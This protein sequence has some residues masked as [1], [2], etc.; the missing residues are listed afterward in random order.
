VV[1]P[2]V[3]ALQDGSS[4]E[5]GA[6]VPGHAR[7]QL[8]QLPFIH[9]PESVGALRN[10]VVALAV[11]EGEE[12][13]ISVAQVMLPAALVQG[14]NGTARSVVRPAPGRVMQGDGGCCKVLQGAAR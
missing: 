4:C 13:C 7:L 9:I 12:I 3:A 1:R 2:L 6:N 14:I 5:G 8:A 11:L 10:A